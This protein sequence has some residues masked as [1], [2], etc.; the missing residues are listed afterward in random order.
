MIFLD[1]LISTQVQC[2]PV[3]SILAALEVKTV[4]LFVLDVE[5]AELAVLNHINFDNVDIEVM[6]YTYLKRKGLAKRE[7]RYF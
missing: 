1:S 7:K 3:E 5:G 2:F 6:Y 4:N